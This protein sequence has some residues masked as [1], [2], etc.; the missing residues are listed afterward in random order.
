VNAFEI[1]AGA[2]ALVAAVAMAGR[3]ILLSPSSSAWPKA[4]AWLRKVLFAGALV[5]VYG[6][7]NLIFAGLGQVL[8]PPTDRIQLIAVL[9]STI[10]VVESAFAA[11]L[12]RQRLPA[13]ITARLE[14]LADIVRVRPK[15]AASIL[16]PAELAAISATS[17][18]GTV[19]APDADA[20]HPVQPGLYH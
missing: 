14:R 5:M 9:M 3:H 20:A 13:R 7:L 1:V 19:W 16:Q 6:G 11:N 10:A 2:G 17:K 18:G 8:L 15:A 12:L 4:P